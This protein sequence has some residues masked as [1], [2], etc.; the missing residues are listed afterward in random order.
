[1]MIHRNVAGVFLMAHAMLVVFIALV[2]AL[3]LVGWRQ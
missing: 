3:L 2:L 1:M